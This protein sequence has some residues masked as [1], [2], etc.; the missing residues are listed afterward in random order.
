MATTFCWATPAAAVLQLDSTT[1]SDL[2][3]LATAAYFLGGVITPGAN[4]PLWASYVLKSKIQA[5]ATK[6]V[7]A[8][9]WFITAMDG[10]NYDVTSG[11]NTPDRAPDFVFNGYAS[12]AANWFQSIPLVVPRPANLFKILFQNVS[13]AT[14]TNVNSDNGLYEVTINEYGV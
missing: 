12:T 4:P 11:T 13:G 2:K 14:H 7:I 1:G 3:N 5:T 10:T 9:C 8:K 6:G